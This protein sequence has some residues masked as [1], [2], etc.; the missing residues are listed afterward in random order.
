MR[1]GTFDPVNSF[2]NTPATSR[3]GLRSC[4]EVPGAAVNFVR[5]LTGGFG[6][7]YFCR[8]EHRRRIF[9]SVFTEQMPP[10]CSGMYP[11]ELTLAILRML[12]P[13]PLII[14]F[15]VEK[16]HSVL[17]SFCSYVQG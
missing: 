5:N 4:T 3:P 6:R 14:L 9:G 15:G 11:T 10:V 1:E 16:H 8:T 7:E 2:R 12:I 17:A 13:L